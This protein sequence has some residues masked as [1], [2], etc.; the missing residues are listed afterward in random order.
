[1]PD[2]L[3]MLSLLDR[4]TWQLE[5]NFSNIQTPF[6]SFLVEAL[7]LRSFYKCDNFLVTG[8][9]LDKKQKRLLKETPVFLM[10]MNTE[11]ILT[12]WTMN[13]NVSFSS[14]LENLSFYSLPVTSGDINK[15]G[16]YSLAKRQN[17]TEYSL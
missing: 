10:L 2:I 14:C 7:A 9:N 16:K 15:K 17:N 5:Y 13:L 3:L 1:M 11:N 12:W 6:M 4:E 8:I